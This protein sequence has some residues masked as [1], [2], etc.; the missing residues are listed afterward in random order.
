[1]KDGEPVGAVRAVWSGG[2]DSL[3]L[4]RLQL[5]VVVVGAVKTVKGRYRKTSEKRIQSIMPRTRSQKSV[6]DVK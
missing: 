1:M 5:R 4:E 2:T 3:A 6:G